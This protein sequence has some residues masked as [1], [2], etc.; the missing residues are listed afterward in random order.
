MVKTTLL[1]KKRKQTSDVSFVN[2]VKRVKQELES[3]SLP[4][5][6]TAIALSKRR[7]VDVLSDVLSRLQGGDRQIASI[8]LREFSI[9]HLPTLSDDIAEVVN[10]IIT[11]ASVTSY[12]Q[13]ARQLLR[14]LLCIM[15]RTDGT[16]WNIVLQRLLSDA[17][18]EAKEGDPPAVC[19][20]KDLKKT[21][22]P[23]DRCLFRCELWGSGQYQQGAST[24]HPNSPFHQNI[25]GRWFVAVTDR[26]SQYRSNIGRLHSRE[27]LL[28]DR[29]LRCADRCLQSSNHGYRCAAIGFHVARVMSRKFTRIYSI[30]TPFG[31][32][33]I[34]NE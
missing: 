2:D 13:I 9:E 30:F 25:F 11:S 31:D 22:V 3:S 24:A 12:D 18:K 26:G 16:L 8:L 1:P 5:R 27:E 17:G 34:F 4:R 20:G 23:I 29:V 10:L 19:C 32:I 15:R 14:M 21:K 6:P 33:S 7:A 28:F